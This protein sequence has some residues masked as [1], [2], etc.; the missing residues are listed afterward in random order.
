M[1]KPH[2]EEASEEKQLKE[3]QEL[4]NIKSDLGLFK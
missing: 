4:R 1:D 3:I 2:E